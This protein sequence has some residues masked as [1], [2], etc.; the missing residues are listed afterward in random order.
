MNFPLAFLQSGRDPINR[1]LINQNQ[2][3]SLRGG[4]PEDV[5]PRHVSGGIPIQRY[6]QNLLDRMPE[7]PVD[8]MFELVSRVNDPDIHVYDVA[9]QDLD[10]LEN[11]VVNRNFFVDNMRDWMERHVRVKVNIDGADRSCYVWQSFLEIHV[12]GSR[13]VYEKTITAGNLDF[14]VNADG[15]LEFY[16]FSVSIGMFFVLKMKRFS[17][18]P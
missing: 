6:L 8:P 13:G 5:I 7:Q 3:L 4:I 9:S 2:T 16:L 1:A 12:D 14:S 18:L 11:P 17:R 15:K 10:A